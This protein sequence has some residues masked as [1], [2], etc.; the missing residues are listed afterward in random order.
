MGE[1]HNISCTFLFVDNEG[2]AAACQRQTTDQRQPRQISIESFRNQQLEFNEAEPTGLL[3]F[4]ST[5]ESKQSECTESID[6]RCFFSGNPFVEIV[7]GII[8][9][10]KKK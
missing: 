6:E 1:F 7:K 4:G 8:H 10:Y 3:P 5:V 2:A 9:I